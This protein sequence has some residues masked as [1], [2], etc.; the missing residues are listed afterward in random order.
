[1]LESSVDGL[2]GSVAGAGP[3]EEREHV[4]GAL[5]QRPPEPADLGERWGTPLVTESITAC[6]MVFPLVLSGSR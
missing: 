5:F 6:I 2:G 3:V 1:M 4:V